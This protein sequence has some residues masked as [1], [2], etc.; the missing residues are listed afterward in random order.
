MEEISSGS[1]THK[2]YSNQWLQREG[3]L[4]SFREKA[5]NWLPD[6]T[7]QS[8]IDLRATLNRLSK[9]YLH[10]T[11]CLCVSKTVT[12]KGKNLRGTWRNDGGVGEG[13]GG[14]ERGREGRGREGRREGKVDMM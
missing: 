11:V 13:R 4:V 6:P 8:N 14:E 10:K 12:V 1:T 5:P 2:D 7:G 9:S 3:Q